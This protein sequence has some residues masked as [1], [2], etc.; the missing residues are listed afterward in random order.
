M[1]R[2]V[3]DLIRVLEPFS[4]L[5]HAGSWVTKRMISVFQWGGV[6]MHCSTCKQMKHLTNAASSSL[7]MRTDLQALLQ[8]MC[9]GVH[10]VIVDFTK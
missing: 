8:Q 6:E 9:G 5:L 7:Y 10:T 4:I 3:K 1:T 2:H